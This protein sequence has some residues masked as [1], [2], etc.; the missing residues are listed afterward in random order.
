MPQVQGNSEVEVIEVETAELDTEV[1]EDYAIEPCDLD[2]KTGRLSNFRPG[3][4][5]VCWIGKEV[6][7][8][9]IRLNGHD[10]RVECDSVSDVSAL[11]LD[12]LTTVT[13]ILRSDTMNVS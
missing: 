1:S 6:R 5:P 2:L 12:S 13:S 11:T 7:T 10:L 8:Y 4:G 3:R 9:N